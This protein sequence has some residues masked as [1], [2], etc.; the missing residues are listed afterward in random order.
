MNDDEIGHARA[1]AQSLNM[2]AT[3]EALAAQW[4]DALADQ[5][6]WAQDEI[7]ALRDREAARA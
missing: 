3:R 4:I 5:L 2:H 7:C 1:F 6:Q